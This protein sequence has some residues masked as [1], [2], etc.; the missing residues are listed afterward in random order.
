MKLNLGDISIRYKFVLIGMSIFTLIAG[1]TF[2]LFSITETQRQKKNLR[3]DVALIA[4]YTAD[5]CS[6]PLFFGIK[7]ETHQILNK[8]NTTE[9]ILFAAIYDQNGELFDSYNPDS[10]EVFTHLIQYP[11]IDSV[12]DSW[13][14]L[15]NNRASINHPIKYQ[16][17]KYGDVIL[18]FSLDNAIKIIKK[19][20]LNALLITLS[21]LL[22]VFI[23]TY[24]LQ[25][26]I[27]EPILALA[28]ISE[29]I[30][31]NGDFSVRLTKGSN[32]EIGALYDRFNNMLEQ[33][34]IRDK[35]R[36][37][38]EQKLKEAKNQAEKADNL[39][40]AFLANMS[41]E[42]R[43]P[44]NSIIGFASLLGD[45]E[46]L[47]EEREEYVELINSSCNTLLHL[48]D[49]IL[50]ISKI[51]AGQLNII[52]SKI[53]VTD[54]LQELYLTFKEINIQINNSLVNVSLH[55]PP[56]L[57]NMT[58][59]T[60]DI[61]LK[62]ILSNLLNNAVKFTESGSIDL[63]VTIIDKI[64]NHKRKRYIK[65]YVRDTGIGIDKGT[66]K[67]IFERFTKIESDSGQLHGGAGLGLTISK[68]LVELLHG[69]IWVESTF[70]KGSSFYITV[71]APSNQYDEISNTP[72]LRKQNAATIDSL[73]IR[74][75]VILIIEDDPSNYELLK[76][77]LRKTGAEIL[78]SR[79]G[80]E[81][82]KTCKESIPDLILMDIKMPEMD[83]FETTKLLR[84]MNI[85]TPIIAQTAY[86][87]IEDEK[88]ILDSGFDAYIS[89][90]IEKEKLLY[91]INK[92]FTEQ[93]SE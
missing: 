91:T 70:G 66:Q 78:W 85:H 37:L 30:K 75:K 76:V 81:G 87:R 68:R 7:E 8:L 14:S 82:I 32:D 71:P 64:K 45:H 80:I 28:L 38:T 11:N 3:H 34:E 26:I 65:F 89:K 36:D 6:A 23:L 92:L 53:N 21:M 83:G 93:K 40:S 57:E 27:T 60:D 41:H 74:N 1:L 63:G 77:L 22:L 12:K 55:I 73:N 33:I 25:K 46:L 90:P 42:I 54:F 43:T 62:Q 84:N 2:T 15:S 13:T 18:H 86:A 10:I 52:I 49:D 31:N 39:K 59:E 72:P 61:R 19:N 51:E 56:S 48:I 5:Y 20:L 35:K 58:F 88:K 29:E 44:M 67:I 47:D 24:Y 16:G 9:N 79:N 69:E 50:D 4:R 17:I